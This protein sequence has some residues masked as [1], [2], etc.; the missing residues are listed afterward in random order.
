M[1]NG[2]V[3]EIFNHDPLVHRMVVLKT[4]IARFPFHDSANT[5]NTGAKSFHYQ[6][7]KK[8]KTKKKDKNGVRIRITPPSKKKKTTPTT[9]GFCTK[10]QNHPPGLTFF[11]QIKIVAHG[12]FVPDSKKIRVTATIAYKTH[13]PSFGK[14]FQGVQRVFVSFVNVRGPYSKRL[15]P[16]TVSQN[17]NDGIHIMDLFGV[18]VVDFRGQRQ[19]QFLVDVVVRSGHVQ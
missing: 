13:M 9:H 16:V 11:T 14:I 4:T 15:Y 5:R 6:A 3:V 8:N 1:F 17:A 2:V 19:I 12:A 18:V 10:R 7:P